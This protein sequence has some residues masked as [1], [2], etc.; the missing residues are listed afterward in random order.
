MTHFTSNRAASS[1]SQD[2]TIFDTRFGYTEKEG[3]L[4]LEA[5]GPKGID[6]YIKIEMVDI[7]LLIQGLFPLTSILINWLSDAL[8]HRITLPPA[9]YL[10]P[11]ALWLIDLFEDS[12]QLLAVYLYQQ[13]SS[14]FGTIIAVASCMNRIK[15][16]LSAVL[17]CSM[18]LLLLIFIG[19]RVTKGLGGQEQ[20][21]QE[22]HKK[23]KKT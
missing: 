23:K 19:D 14:S 22:A 20:Q 13:S 3:R 12:T 18:L 7:L 17:G 2:V 1:P 5:W 21:Q 16:S 9:Y 10:L 11:P 6:V 4:L 8:I 15:W